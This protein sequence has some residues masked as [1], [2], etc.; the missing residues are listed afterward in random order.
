MWP[1][2]SQGRLP[3]FRQRILGPFWATFWKTLETKTASKDEV[4]FMHTFGVEI[5]STNDGFCYQFHTLWRWYFT[6]SYEIRKVYFWTTVQV[7]WRILT[8][9]KVHWSFVLEEQ[10]DLKTNLETDLNL[11]PILEEFGYNKLLEIRHQIHLKTS[12]DATSFLEQ[13]FGTLGAA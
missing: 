11:G 12:L 3:Q 2:G 6:I 5:W 1:K 8:F 7:F 13:F 4:C 9:S 10:I